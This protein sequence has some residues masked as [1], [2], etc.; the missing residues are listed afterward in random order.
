[1]KIEPKDFILFEE[2]LQLAQHKYVEQLPF[3]CF[4]YPNHKSVWLIGQEDNTLHYFT[5]HKK[6]QK[7][8]IFAPFDTANSPIILTP[9]NVT[10]SNL[11][12]Q[13]IAESNYFG[14]AQ[15]T[16]A[17][18][19]AHIDLVTKA[20]EQ[21]HQGAFEK[22]VLSRKITLPFVANPFKSFAN[23]VI[24]YPSAYCYLFFHPK[25]GT[26]LAATPELL[27]FNDNNNFN[28][29]ALA[30]TIPSPTL[31]KNTIEWQPKEREEQQ[32]VTD[33]IVQQLQGYVDQFEIS[34]PKTIQ[35][36]KV[37]HLCTEI[38][39]KIKEGKA[40]DV[41]KSLHPTPAVCGYPTNKARKFIIEN[42]LYD[43][44][45]YTG[46]CGEISDNFQA[47]YVNLRCM[48]ITNTETYLYVGGGITKDS[49][50]EKE[51]EETQNKAMTMKLVVSTDTNN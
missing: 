14:T 38:K 40:F 41:I 17:E 47:L 3:V 1:M 31:K 28:T 32:I 5:P 30:G 44:Q 19:Q 22:V 21:I 34:I 49:I 9:D 7:G 25:V 11:P 45:Y 48:Q 13:E 12:I 10:I 20:I 27:L 33:T 26:W 51:Y 43:R 4:K 24:C 18:K 35:A 16:E 46:Y 8:F 37:M 23:M 39:G 50:P 15:E 6:V 42:E 36:G 2:L 29:M